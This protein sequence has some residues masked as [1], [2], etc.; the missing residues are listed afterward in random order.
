MECLWLTGYQVSEELMRR[1]V[2]VEGVG[3]VLRSTDDVVWS[4]CEEEGG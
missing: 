3:T 1:R 4:Y 2:G